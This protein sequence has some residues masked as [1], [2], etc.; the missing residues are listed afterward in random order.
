M[1]G[2]LQSIGD[3]IPDGRMVRPGSDPKLVKGVQEH[4]IHFMDSTPH[5]RRALDMGPR[6]KRCLGFF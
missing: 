4:R 2:A 3:C 6:Y 1:T 5:R